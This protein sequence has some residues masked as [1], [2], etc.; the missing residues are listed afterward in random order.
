M[1]RA[2]AVE[3]LSTTPIRTIALAKKVDLLALLPKQDTDQLFSWVRNN[4]GI[5]AWG[6][7]AK[8]NF[9]GSERFSRAHKWW[10]DFI[11]NS[12]IRDEIQ[13]S[14]SGAIAFISF[15]YQSDQS[16]VVAIPK[17]IVG[18]NSESTWLT[19]IGDL[20]IEEIKKNLSKQQE[21]PVAPVN[22]TWQD[23]SISV[24]QW[25]SAVD[26]AVTRI[27]NKEL[28]K[29]VLTRDLKAEA[30]SN[31]DIR[32]V[33]KNLSDSYPEC[34]TFSVDGLIG[35]TPE[36]LVRRT[37]NAV[38][39]R[40]L[41]GTIKRDNSRIDSELD[42]TL[43]Q[44]DKDLEEH[45]FAVTSVATALALHCTDMKVPENPRVLRLSNVAHLATDISGSLVD[46]A[47]ALVLAGSLHPTAAICGTPTGRAKI[48]ISELEQMD[49]NR[50]TGPVG[51]INAKGDGELGIALRCA[52]I[53]K[54]TARLFAGCGIVSESNAVDELAESNAKFI[55][56]REALS[57]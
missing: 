37:G 16:S 3:N 30:D 13:T 9:M 22:L 41:A 55:A 57:K 50:Y 24:A 48:L 32:Y 4:Q 53:S 6:V 54:K 51:W 17:V 31:I 18:Q 36:L 21:Q 44:S 2:T 25:Q 49:R 52:E 42:T 45:E 33:L 26:K 27:N 56:I 5:V 15:A 35:A 28:D 47:P 34:W 1:A 23:G 14:E 7:H 20:D 40:V 38:L 12:A 19:V 46:A 11:D 29:V 43:L 39:S 8:E 10:K